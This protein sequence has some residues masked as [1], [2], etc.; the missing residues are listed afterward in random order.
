[1]AEQDDAAP[2]GWQVPQG[3]ALLAMLLIPLLLALAVWGSARVYDRRVKPRL[4]R[5]VATFPAPGIE[6][7]I[8]DGESDPVRTPARPHADAAIE[9]AKR[10]LVADARQSAGG[11]R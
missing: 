4:Y 2:E 11:A 1:M 5:D 7:Y 9:A 8:H 10:S 3:R 6:T